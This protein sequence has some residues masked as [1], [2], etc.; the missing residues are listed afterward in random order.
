MI[1][2]RSKK[3]FLKVVNKQDAN[4][5]LDVIEKYVQPGTTTNYEHVDGLQFSRN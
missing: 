4:A 1:D 3:L 5:L 2:R